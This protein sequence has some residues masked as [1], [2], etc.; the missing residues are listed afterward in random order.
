VNLFDIPSP[1]AV[2]VLLSLLAVAVR[3]I[4]PRPGDSDG[5]F[6]SP[7]DLGWPK[8][9]QEEDPVP[10]RVELLSRRWG[11]S[12]G[13]GARTAESVNGRSNPMFQDV[14]A[15]PTRSRVVTPYARR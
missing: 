10:W 12:A 4:G 9:V 8:G 11:V 14:E 1:I 13:Q 7:T 5:L 3:F 15:R 6:R 2:I